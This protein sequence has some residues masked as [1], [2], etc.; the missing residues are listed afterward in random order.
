SQISDSSI[1]KLL[2]GARIVVIVITQPA[3]L[4]VD[5]KPYSKIFV[6]HTAASIGVVILS[7]SL[8]AYES[9]NDKRHRNKEFFSKIA[10]SFIILFNLNVV[11]CR[12]SIFMKYSYTLKYLFFLILT[13]LS[14]TSCRL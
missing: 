3:D 6:I 7:L 9:G 2:Y 13:H 14:I 8:V 5:R 4:W 11:L 1:R 10:H 12:N